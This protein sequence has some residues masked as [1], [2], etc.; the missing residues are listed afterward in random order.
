MFRSSSPPLGIGRWLRSESGSAVLLIVVTTFALLWA[1]SPLSSSY[2]EL[3]H[4]SVGIDVGP[5]GLHLD[6]PGH[7]VGDSRLVGV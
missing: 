3:W 6:V 1:N 4:Q 5:F 2:F 7:H